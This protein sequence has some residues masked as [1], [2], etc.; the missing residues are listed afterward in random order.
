MAVWRAFKPRNV[1]VAAS[2][3]S[4]SAYIDI[5]LNNPSFL[6]DNNLHAP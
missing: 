4:E 5:N 1:A 2:K 3:L 6:A